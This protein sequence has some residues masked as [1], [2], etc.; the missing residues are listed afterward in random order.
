MR[1]GPLTD[2]CTAVRAVFLFF[3]GFPAGC[4]IHDPRGS[5]CVGTTGFGFRNRI[6]QGR[7]FL[8]FRYCSRCRLGRFFLSA[9]G[10]CRSSVS[11][12]LIVMSQRRK[13]CTV[14]QHVSAFVS[15]PAPMINL[16]ICLTGCFPNQFPFFN[17]FML[18]SFNGPGIQHFA[19]VLTVFLCGAFL[20]AGGFP[21][22]PAVPVRVCAGLQFRNCN[23]TGC[24]AV[25]ARLG[26]LS[27]V[28]CCCS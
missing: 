28:L 8:W 4:F 9:A 14:S 1:N 12:Y 2:D 18:C 19:A 23:G 16:P 24:P 11:V 26:A 22:Y 21:G 5:V 20:P 25:S 10:T 27:F 6:R 17:P 3:S 15:V 13:R 7:F